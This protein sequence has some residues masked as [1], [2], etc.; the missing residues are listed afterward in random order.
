MEEV[1]HLRT[2]Y[3]GKQILVASRKA[4][5]LMR[6]DGSGYDYLIVIKYTSINI[7]QHIGCEEA[8]G[9]GFDFGRR[10]GSD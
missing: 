6:E 5:Y 2:A 9:K 8:I 3:S 4:Y 10:N 1:K 7:D